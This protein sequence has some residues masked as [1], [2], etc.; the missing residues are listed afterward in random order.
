MISTTSFPEH[1][2]WGGAIAANQAEGAWNEDG[3]GPSINDALRH[4]I[5]NGVLDDAIDPNAYYPSHEAIDFYHRYKE[6]VAL[7]AEMGF[8]CLRTSIAWSRISPTGMNS[9]LTKRACNFTTI[10]S[11]NCSSMVSSRSL[12]FPTLRLRCIWCGNTAAGRTGSWWLF[13]AVLRSH[14]QALQK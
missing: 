12:P 11:T 5:V 4:G 7:F 14:L 6:D 2:L 9:S 13:Y 3:R 10:C 8:K 1:F